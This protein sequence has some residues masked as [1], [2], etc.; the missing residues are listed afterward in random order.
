VAQA[1]A[2]GI[3]PQLLLVAVLL[4]ILA[5]GCSL[6]TLSMM[7]GE[8]ELEGVWDGVS[9]NGCPAQEHD[10]RCRAVHRISFTILRENAK[11]FGFYHCAPGTMPC[12][13]RVESDL[14]DTGEIK[15]LQFRRSTLWFRVMRNDHSSC[16]FNT[17]PSANR[18]RGGFYCSG[19]ER[20]YWQVERVY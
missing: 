5:S 11:T 2:V 3:F 16:L 15:S 14:A 9:V 18:M 10:T 20:G 17:I 12:Y 7:E 4:E 1:R 13:D 8:S 6:Q 19:I